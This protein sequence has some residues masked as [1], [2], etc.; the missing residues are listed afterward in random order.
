[1]GRREFFAPAAWNALAL[2]ATEK[3]NIVFFLGD[4]PG[5]AD[6]GCYSGK[7]HET[8]QNA[9]MPAPNPNFDSAQ[10]AQGTGW[11]WMACEGA[12]DGT[13]IR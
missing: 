9:V 2:A 3:P 5:W 8:P 6:L 11:K 7:F 12:E 4:D 10:A 13:Q 1:M